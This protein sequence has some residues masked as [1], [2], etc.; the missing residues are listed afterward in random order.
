[1]I[2]MIKQKHRIN[3]RLVFFDI[4]NIG[5]SIGLY[6]NKVSPTQIIAIGELVEDGKVKKESY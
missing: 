4:K 5:K 3:I 2:Y 6:H 1:M